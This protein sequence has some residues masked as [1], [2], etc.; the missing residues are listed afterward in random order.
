MQSG[1]G[2]LLNDEYPIAFA[3]NFARRLWSAIKVPL[4]LVFAERSHTR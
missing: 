4:F 2:V 3:M 1:R